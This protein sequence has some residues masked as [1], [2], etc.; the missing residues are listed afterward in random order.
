MSGPIQ[1]YWVTR[2]Y[3]TLQKR[4]RTFALPPPP[5][6][7]LWLSVWFFPSILR[8][9]FSLYKGRFFPLFSPNYVCVH[10]LKCIFCLF[11]PC[12]HMQTPH[13]GWVHDVLC[14]QE[15]MGRNWDL[16]KWHGSPRLTPD[17]VS[18]FTECLFPDSPQPSNQLSASFPSQQQAQQPHR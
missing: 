14:W 2:K 5:P 12:Y 11:W 10:M 15:W 16:W 6:N 7:M 8:H 17:W 9:Y 18:S 3:C 4:G 1:C 13:A